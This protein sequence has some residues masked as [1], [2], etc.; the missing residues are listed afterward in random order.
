MNRIVEKIIN[1]EGR[2]VTVSPISLEYKNLL[3]TFEDSRS[4]AFYAMGVAIKEAKPVYLLVPGEYIT[5]VYT[6]VTEAWFQKANVIVIALFSSISS[7][8]TTWCDRCTLVS[9]NCHISETDV[10]EQFLAETEGLHGPA[11]LNVVYEN[12]SETKTDYSDAIGALREA[13]R[14]L[15]IR[16]YNPKITSDV[17]V[18]PPT[19]KYGVLSKYIGM[20]AVKDCGILLCNADPVLVDINIFRTRY[21]NN[22]MKIVIYDDGRLYD[23]KVSSWIQSNEW[24]CKVVSSINIDSARWL[25]DNENASVLI[26]GEER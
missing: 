18:I 24:E 23:K 15:A 25:L 11:L 12:S 7:V 26:I 16:C 1:G 14:N 20:S 6:A 17:I 19:D 2:I 5:S 22:N 13:N 8:K 9:E 21:R 3:A 10:I 4:A